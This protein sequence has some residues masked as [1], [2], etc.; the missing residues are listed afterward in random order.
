MD[1]YRILVFSDCNNRARE[2]EFNRW[3]EDV[4][5]PDML[6][7]PGIMRATRWLSVQVDNP[8]AK[9]Y[10]A[11][12]ELETADLPKFSQDMSRIVESARQRGRLSDL[13]VFDPP[14]VPR[15][16]RQIMAVR[17]AKR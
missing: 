2:E 15:L 12:Y 11:L 5:I 17:E 3:Y 13:P 6:Q 10:L 7:V 14:G 16:Y 4:H 8:R 1:Q 9:K